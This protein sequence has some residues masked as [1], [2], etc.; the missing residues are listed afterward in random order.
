[1]NWPF[2]EGGWWSNIQGQKKSLLSEGTKIECGMVGD[3]D[4]GAVPWVRSQ[5]GGRQSSARA[6]PLLSEAGK[7][8]CNRNPVC[9]FPLLWFSP[10]LTPPHT[11]T[12]MAISGHKM[13][14]TLCLKINYKCNSKKGPDQIHLD[15]CPPVSDIKPI[16]WS[17]RQPVLQQAQLQKEISSRFLQTFLSFISTK[18]LWNKLCLWE[19]L[20]KSVFQLRAAIYCFGTRSVLEFCLKSCIFDPRDKL[21][22]TSEQQEN[23]TLRPQSFFWLF[24]SS[25]IWN[26]IN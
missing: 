1:M 21:W 4:L 15:T 2:L 10:L 18:P 3:D 24:C 22:E 23:K 25:L 7:R 16:C 6:E 9:S 14:T 13:N 26:M 12:Q 19:T 8:Q 5:H 11:H 20:R 17:N